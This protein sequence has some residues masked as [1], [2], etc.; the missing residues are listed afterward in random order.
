MNRVCVSSLFPIEID[1]D[2]DEWVR[3]AMF[4]SGG[5]HYV[6]DICLRT[7]RATLLGF[8]RL[9]DKASVPLGMV[10]YADPNVDILH[11]LEL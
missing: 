2:G 7:W 11:E 4:G 6:V 9:R 10:H 3:L 1:G 8:F 5:L